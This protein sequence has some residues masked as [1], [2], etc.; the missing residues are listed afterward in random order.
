MD[1]WIRS[2]MSRP[3]D[4]LYSARRLAVVLQGH[5]RMTAD[6]DL[7][8]ES[9]GSPKKLLGSTVFPLPSNALPR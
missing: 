2:L 4:E 1:L 3:G 5:P 8:M 7:V 6:I 9:N